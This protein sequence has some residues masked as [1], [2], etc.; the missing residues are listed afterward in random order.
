MEE[1]KYVD[2]GHVQELLKLIKARDSFHDWSSEYEKYNRKVKNTIEWLERNA[3]NIEE[4]IKYGK[5]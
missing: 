3:M 4:V 5:M 2:L 1:K